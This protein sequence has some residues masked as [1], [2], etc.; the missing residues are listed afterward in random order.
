MKKIIIII[1]LGISAVSACEEIPENECG[2]CDGIFSTTIT[3][4]IHEELVSCDDGTD[5]RCNYVQYGNEIDEEAWEVFPHEICSFDFKP[6][7]RYTLLVKKQKI[8]KDD[9]GNKIYR[10]C[11]VS[12]Q[13]MEKVYL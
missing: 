4:Q 8:G 12:I 10:Y 2:T 3:M 13:N 6:G 9:D 11:L 5:N 7:Y 1:F